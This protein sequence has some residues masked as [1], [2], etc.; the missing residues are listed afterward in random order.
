MRLFDRARQQRR[1]EI[2][3]RQ[4]VQD[5]VEQTGLP[6]RIVRDEF[7]L[8]AEEVFAALTSRI[9]GQDDACRAA[10]NAILRLKSGLNDPQRPI[11]V[12]LFCGPTGVGKTELAKALTDYLFGHGGATDR[13]V[14]LDMSEYSSPWAAQRLLAKDDRTPSELIQRV[15]QQPFVTVLLDE[16][17]KAAPEVFD[18]LLGLLDEGRLTDPFG[19]TTDFRSAILVMTSN[20]GT[21]NRQ[22]IG[23]A[24]ET[25]EGYDAEV[26][27]FF[28]PEFYNRIDAVVTFRPLSPEVCLAITRKELAAIAAREGLVKAGLRLAFS[29]ALTQYL[30]RTGFDSRYGARPLQRTL[31]ARVVSELSRYL[32]AHP[33]LSDREI[34]LNVDRQGQVVVDAVTS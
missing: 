25:A 12:L 21:S 20:L 3:V 28:R 29:D 10:G 30:A 31:E 33:G 34:H 9:V 24:G 18:I 11:G 14:R 5:F 6:E 7:P 26:R 2:P 15:R 8:P 27:A 19:R 17:E 16:I 32:I 4:A 1:S 23:F 13:L 22:S